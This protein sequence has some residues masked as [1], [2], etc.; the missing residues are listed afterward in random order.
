MDFRESAVC[1]DEVA[2]SSRSRYLC[3]IEEMYIENSE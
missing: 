2:G 1:L 3:M